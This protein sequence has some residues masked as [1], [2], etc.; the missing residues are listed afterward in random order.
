MQRVDQASSANNSGPVLVVV[1]DGDIH[2][3]FE[4]LLNDEALRRFDIFEVD[5]SK[6]WTKQTNSAAEF[7]WV[8]GI[9]FEVDRVH[10]CEPFKQDGLAFHHGLGCQ[11][12]EVTKA[13]NSRA[14]RDHSH[15]VALVGVVICRLRAGG[16]FFTRDCNTRRISKRQIPLGHHGHGR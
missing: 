8:F 1:K 14:V 15:K 4:T 5:A 2:L 13:Q 9:N 16:D 3:F 12:A 10:I 7:I 11:R 6:R